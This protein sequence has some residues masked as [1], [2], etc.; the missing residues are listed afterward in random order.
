MKENLLELNLKDLGIDTN[1]YCSY[2][3]NAE[4]DKYEG[5]LING[6]KK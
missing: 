2:I 6:K 4:N 3:Q 5:E 1:T